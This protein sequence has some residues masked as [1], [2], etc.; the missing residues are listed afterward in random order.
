MMS[1]PVFCK[2]LHLSAVTRP[3]KFWFN[4]VAIL[5]E[6][7]C[8]GNMALEA[9]SVL[10][11]RAVWLVA[12]SAFLELSMNRMACITVKLG[13]FAGFAFH[14]R[15]RALMTGCTHRFNVFQF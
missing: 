7:W 5:Q 4:L 15:K 11:V 1:G 9:V 12:L 3:A 10:H 13:M 6:G 8:M 14:V 2:L